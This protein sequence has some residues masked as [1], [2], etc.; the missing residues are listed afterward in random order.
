MAD[1]NMCITYA[2][3]FLDAVIWMNWGVSVV[4]SLNDDGK[5]A[6]YMFYR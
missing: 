5:M 4:I 3:H 1:D 2:V 6:N